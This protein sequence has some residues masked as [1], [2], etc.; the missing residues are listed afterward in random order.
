MLQLA[1][2]HDAQ[3]QRLARCVAQYRKKLLIPPRWQIDVAVLCPDEMTDYY[4]EEGIQASLAWQPLEYANY[5]MRM[6][7]EVP[8][9]TVDWLI[10][11]ELLEA[12]SAPYAVFANELIQHQRRNKSELDAQHRLIRDDLIEW[13]LAIIAPDKRPSV[14]SRI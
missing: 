11:H 5:R 14:G 10:M 4:G 13:M 12:V 3:Y 2:S 7:C 8:E 1:D 6:S 9:D